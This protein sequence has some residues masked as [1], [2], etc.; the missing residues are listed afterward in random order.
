MQL[1][2]LLKDL[3]ARTE[4]EHKGLLPIEWLTLGYV[5][6][7]S[8][9]MLLFGSG[10]NNLPWMVTLR[11]MAVGLVALGF[12]LYRRFP[13][14]LAVLARVTF[15][16]ALLALWYP[17]LYQFSR[18]HHNLDHVVAALEQ[19]IFAC[20]PSILFSENF[21]SHFF[22]ECFYMGYL[23]YFPMI[24]TLL[25]YYFFMRGYEFPR[26]SAVVLGAFFLYYIVFLFV[27]VAG[28]QYY[29]N[30]IGLEAARAG[31][32]TPVGMWFDSSIEMMEPPGW[33]GGFFYQ[34]LEV[35]R[36]SERPVASFPSSHVGVSTII[37]ILAL[38]TRCG[39]LIGI[40]FPLWV[41]LCCATV[42][43]R[44]HYVIDVAAGFITAP[45][46]FWILSRPKI[47]GPLKSPGR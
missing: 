12:Y 29:F 31:E 7:T 26:V 28:P 9:L 10:M 3:V 4:P 38:R 14:K 19:S 30:A 34:V 41:F 21:T 39:W 42:Y 24:G 44:A 47:F 20:Q 25:L 37:M 5:T 32:F 8:V 17:D 22:S 43:I 18:L 35:L 36:E 16:I 23:F 11:G 27:P 40:L 2:A 13:S 33:K 45:I 15:Q 46:V 6:L 1:K